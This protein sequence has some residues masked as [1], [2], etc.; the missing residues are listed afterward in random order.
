MGYMYPEV[1]VDTEWILQNLPDE[2][3]RL[4]FDYHPLQYVLKMKKCKIPFLFL[5]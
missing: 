3:W 4:K 1:L 5:T 2:N